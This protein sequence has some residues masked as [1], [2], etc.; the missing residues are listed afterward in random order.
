MPRLLEQH[1]GRLYGLA[2]RICGRRDEAEDLVQEIF[3]QAWRKWE[4]FDGRSDPVV[5]LFTIAHRACQRMHRK[6]AGEPE[7][8]ESLDELLPLGSRKVAV[9]PADTDEFDE[10]V[11]RE[12]RQAVGAAVTALPTEFRI[13]NFA[14]AWTVARLGT[15]AFNSVWITAVS[16]A[17]ILALSSM[18]AFA[19]ARLEF[20]GRNVLF[21]VFLIGLIIPIQGV[22][23]P[24]FLL[25][26]KMG[27][28][29]TY[30]GLI[31][32]YV[33]WG[34]PLAIFNQFNQ[35]AKPP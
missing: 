8:V 2:S 16:V 19:F 10:Q 1:G 11:R 18:A 7:R 29:Y 21:G 20:R 13:H 9:L 4:Q 33:A 23:V 30:P 34:L 22:L 15:Y 17:G 35:S 28:L 31:L 3:V 12:Q 27:L 24:L 26:K 14:K 5:W 32:S 25:L 6:R